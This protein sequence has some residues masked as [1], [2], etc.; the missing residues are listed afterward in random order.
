MYPIHIFGTKVVYIFLY[1]CAADCIRLILSVKAE[2]NAWSVDHFFRR[3]IFQLP[4][5]TFLEHYILAGKV[6]LRK[7]TLLCFHCSLFR[8]QVALNIGS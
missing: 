8:K 4:S 2:M 7:S 6:R 1:I 3:T 5:I